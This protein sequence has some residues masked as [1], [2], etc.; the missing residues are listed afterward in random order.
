[1]SIRRR[2]LTDSL[3][4][5]SPRGLADSLA[6]LDVCLVLVAVLL[7]LPRV[8]VV[9]SLLLVPGVAIA[10]DDVALSHGVPLAAHPSGGLLLLLDWDRRSGHVLQ[11]EM[12][13]IDIL[14]EHTQ[15]V[16]IACAKYC[17]THGSLSVIHMTQSCHD[18]TDLHHTID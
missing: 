14:M 18:K 12:L 3:R 16:Y 5:G 2:I 9:V 1:M 11:Q 13:M 4:R 17:R 8:P 6:L 7:L 10:A 15:S